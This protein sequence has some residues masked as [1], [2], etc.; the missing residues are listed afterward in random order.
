VKDGKW[1][2]GRHQ[3][4]ELRMQRR[5]DLSAVAHRA[6]NGRRGV[7]AASVR[8][9]R[10]VFD[11]SLGP[12]SGDHQ[13]PGRQRSAASHGRFRADHVVFRRCA[14]QQ[15][16]RRSRGPVRRSTTSRHVCHRS[17]GQFRDYDRSRLPAE[18]TYRFGERPCSVVAGSPACSSTTATAHRPGHR[19][20]ARTAATWP[21]RLLNSPFAFPGRSGKCSLPPPG[22]GRPIRLGPL[23]RPD[24]TATAA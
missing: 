22:D 2:V 21:P 5:A 12:G 4:A 18:T 6:H 10:G 11:H 13:C 1:L 7:C 9:Y 15:A 20:L 3:G 16:A 14:D 8:R 17:P 24:R 19:A 23:R